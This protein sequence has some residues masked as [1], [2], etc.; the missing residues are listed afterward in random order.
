MYINRTFDMVAEAVPDTPILNLKELKALLPHVEQSRTNLRILEC[1]KL[2]LQPQSLTSVGKLGKFFHDAGHLRS[3]AELYDEVLKTPGSKEQQVSYYTV[4]NSRGAIFLDQSRFSEAYKLFQE[5]RRYLDSDMAPAELEPRLL[6]CNINLAI[7]HRNERH[8]DKAESIL[9]ET[10][11]VC[12]KQ[13]LKDD[14]SRFQSYRI[15]HFLSTVC[16]LGGH[17]SDAADYASDAKNGLQSM[18]GTDSLYTLQAAQQL[19]SV[20][21]RRKFFDDAAKELAFAR[22]GFEH[23]FSPTDQFWLE[24]HWHHIM[25]QSDRL[26]DVGSPSRAHLVEAFEDLIQKQQKQ[27]G[28]TH[29]LTL[30]TVRAYGN[31]LSDWGDLAKGKWYLCRAIEGYDSELLKCRSRQNSWARTMAAL[32]LAQN[33]WIQAQEHKKDLLGKA[34]QIYDEARGQLEGDSSTLAQRHLQDIILNR[35]RILCLMGPEAAKRDALQE[36]LQSPDISEEDKRWAAKR[37]Y[38]RQHP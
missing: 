10:L 14:H 34:L 24:H 36:V 9:K 22:K 13:E 35:A 19:G 18:G 37:L 31:K 12:E 1:E 33:L 26:E 27:L 29:W 25:L 2:E 21:R 3:A 23:L 7:Q 6:E 32:D 15:K 38:A 11:D 16:V 20:Y 30:R 5:V 28:E 8:L 4:M 17:L